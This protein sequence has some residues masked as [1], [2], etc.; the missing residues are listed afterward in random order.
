M[1]NVWLSGRLQGQTFIP[2]GVLSFC[3]GW[4]KYNEII[5]LRVELN[6][7]KTYLLFLQNKHR[8]DYIK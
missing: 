2:L 8:P 4:L 5:E 1:I 3:T 6:K 7:R